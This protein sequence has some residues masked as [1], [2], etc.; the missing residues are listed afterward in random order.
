MRNVPIL[1]Q[2]QDI[3][4]VAMHARG[5]KALISARRHGG[6]FDVFLSHRTPKSKGDGGRDVWT[7]PLPLDGLNSPRPMTCSRNGMAVD[8]SFATNRSGTFE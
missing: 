4:H 2:F 5:R 6:D 3:Q 8:I 1:G 7:T